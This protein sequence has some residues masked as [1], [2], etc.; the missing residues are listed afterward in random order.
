MDL[1]NKLFPVSSIVKSDNLTTLIVAVAIYI[2]AGAVVH[3]VMGLFVW[4][5]LVGWIFKLVRWLV[6][7]Y[8]VLGTLLA[9]LHYF[10]IA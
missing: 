7:T 9:V 10:K 8:C 4:M 5:P 1:I 3:F 2:V 6:S